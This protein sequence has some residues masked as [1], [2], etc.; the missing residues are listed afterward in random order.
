MKLNT[1]IDLGRMIRDERKSRQWTQAILAEKV[2]L[3]QKDISRIENDTAKV[4]LHT[5]LGVCAALDIQLSAIRSNS[6][7][8]PS[9]TL[10]F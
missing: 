1:P 6:G 8:A 5:L 3:L 2:G 4:D 7:N 10:G 9:S